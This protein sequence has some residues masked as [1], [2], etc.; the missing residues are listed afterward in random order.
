MKS[1]KAIVLTGRSLP[2]GKTKGNKFSKEYVESV[3]VCEIDPS[4]MKELGIFEGQ[5]VKIVTKWGQ[6]VLKAITSKQVPHKGIIFIPYGLWSSFLVN[7]E[8][9]GTG[10][11]SLK[12]VEAEIFPAISEK[13]TSIEEFL[14]QF[15]KR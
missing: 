11:P 1:I 5:N 15:L 13:V 6:V 9:N 3:A 8:T 2:Q 4:D 12:G 10:M 14:N 7:P